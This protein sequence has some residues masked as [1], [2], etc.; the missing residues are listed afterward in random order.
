M[1]CCKFCLIRLARNIYCASVIRYQGYC[2]LAGK[3]E[4]M[5]S[6]VR[7]PFREIS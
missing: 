4:H 2:M 6:F 5:R 7:D 3:V 1:Q